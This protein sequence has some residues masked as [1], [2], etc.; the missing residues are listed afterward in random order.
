M[1]TQ[2]V[3]DVIKLVIN[4]DL[5]KELPPLTTEQFTELKKGIR[6]DGVLDAVKY[7]RNP[8]T[9][10]NEIIDGHNRH[11]IAQELDIDYPIQFLSFDSLN[12]VKYWMHRNGAGRRDGKANLER[13]AELLTLI[14]QERHPNVSKT[15]IVKEVAKDANVSDRTVWRAVTDHE[16]ATVTPEQ[17]SA[18]ALKVIARM[19]AKL[20]DDDRA[21]LRELLD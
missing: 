5:D 21:R 7:W 13:M 19:I 12:G 17:Q 8:D 11:R 15:E 9:R 1:K 18:S 14:K 20:T 16:P 4:P 10:K 2:P 3:T 6:R